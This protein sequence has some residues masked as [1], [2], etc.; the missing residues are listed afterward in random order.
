MKNKI[1]NLKLLLI[2]LIFLILYN[3]AVFSK[4]LNLKALE[5]LTYEEGNLIIGKSEV[6]A[7]IK[8]EIKIFADKVTYNKKI[9]EI[10]AEGNVKAVDLINNTEISSQKMIYYKD[11]QQIISFDE[12]FFDTNKKIRGNSSNVFLI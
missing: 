10:I 3:N 2:N 6:E 8:N 5:V 12:T 1:F 9:A 7:E 11:K 4:E